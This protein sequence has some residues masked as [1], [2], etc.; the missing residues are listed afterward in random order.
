MFII[1][2]KEEIKASHVSAIP[3][4][5]ANSTNASNNSG[6]AEDSHAQQR[7]KDSSRNQKPFLVGRTGVN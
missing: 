7:S 1:H 3:K 4:E 2:V 6:T 5:A